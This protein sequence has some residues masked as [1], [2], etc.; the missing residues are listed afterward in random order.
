MASTLRIHLIFLAVALR[1]LALVPT[2]EDGNQALAIMSRMAANASAA[3]DARR[4]YVYHQQVRAALSRSGGQLARK[5]TRDYTVTP[6]ESI[7]EK[8]LTSF[9]GEYRS[10]KRMAV[11]TRPGIKDAGDQGDREAIEELIDGLV[12]AKNTRD[13]IPPALFP[14][15][16]NDLGHY[17]FSLKGETT[18]R[19]RRAYEIHFEP[20]DMNGVCIHVG[21]D[22]ETPCYRWTGEVWIDMEDY[23]P[24]RIET[25]LAKGVPWGLRVFMGVDVRQYGFSVNYNR[26]AEKVWFPVSYG[27][28]FRITVFWGYKR[29][30]ALSMENNDFRRTDATF[31]IHFDFPQ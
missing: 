17:V 15:H 2:E 19:G 3:T 8:T 5:E 4:Q 10:G 12:N 30:V 25:K 21:A 1:A 13:G 31:T 7:T 26:V 24:I 9:S 14:L 29:T 16:S 18:L 11:Y 22:E 6:R 28:E 23:E 27:T 20:T